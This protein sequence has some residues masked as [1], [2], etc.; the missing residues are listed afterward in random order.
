MR[1]VTFLFLLT[2]RSGKPASDPRMDIDSLLA[3]DSIR[4]GDA[5]LFTFYGHMEWEPWLEYATTTTSESED[6]Q[7]RNA[8]TKEPGDFDN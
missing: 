6:A 1:T 4:C 2:T 7:K 3:D 5:S 8:A